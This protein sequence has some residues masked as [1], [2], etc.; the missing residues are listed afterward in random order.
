LIETGSVRF[1]LA[2]TIHCGQT[3]PTHPDGPWIRVGDEGGANPAT[4][5][6]V[7]RSGDR[8]LAVN[9]APAE[10]DRAQV[11]AEEMGQLL[12]GVDWQWFDEAERGTAVDQTELWR[13]FLAAMVACLFVEAALIF[14]EKPAAQGTPAIRRTSSQPKSGRQRAA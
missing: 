10:A 13:W 2:S 5:T 8:W 1:S 7:Y 6:G 11:E 12:D 4:E 9:W 14:P 3:P